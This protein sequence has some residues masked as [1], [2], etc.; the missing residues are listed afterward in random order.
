M[1][2]GADPRSG[3]K[4]SLSGGP[5]GLFGFFFWE[6]TVFKLKRHI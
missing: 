3:N 5:R 6:D 1:R 4:R 2:G